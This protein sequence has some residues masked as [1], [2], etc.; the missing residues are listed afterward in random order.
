M[1]NKMFPLIL[2]L[3]AAGVLIAACTTPAAQAQI[4]AESGSEPRRTINVTGSGQVTL[5]PD[6]ARVSIG[7]RTEAE[8]AAQAVADNNE[9][10]QAVI[11]ALLAAGIAAEDISTTNFN[12]YPIEDYDFEGRRAGVTYSVDN[13]VFVTV[14]DLDALGD[15]LSAAIEA[16]ANNIYG[17][18]FDV[19][20]K[21]AALAQARE[22][23]VADARTQAE[24]LASLTG[25]E[26][27]AVQSINVFGN[28]PTPFMGRG[29]GN[30]AMEEALMAVPVS[31]GQFTLSV[32]VNV[33]YEIR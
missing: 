21:E 3:L 6:V 16:G 23:A 13:T 12:L 26:L 18:Q 19:A 9:Q 22:L 25:V 10:A 30:F 5:T 15:V 24:H 8:D 27:G 28:F 33:V 20:D 17:I 7:V 11:D 1:R 4:A 2:L 14:R 32:Q 29:G 31:P